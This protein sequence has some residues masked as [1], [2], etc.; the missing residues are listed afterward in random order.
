VFG[1]LP[2]SEPVNLEALAHHTSGLLCLRGP[3]NN[4]EQSALADERA[5]RTGM[6]L[7]KWL[8]VRPSGSKDGRKGAAVEPAAAEIR[9]ERGASA[10]ARAL[11]LKWRRDD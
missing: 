7:G 8:S 11:F 10:A 1:R 5:V 2:L 9:T 4:L 3:V 6:G